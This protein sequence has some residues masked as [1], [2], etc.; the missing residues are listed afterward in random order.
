MQIQITLRKNRTLP[1][2]F[3]VMNTAATPVLG[4]I[5][6]LGKADNAAAN[7]Q[8]NA[9]RNPE[10]SFGDTPTGGYAITALVPHHGETDLH[11]YGP[12]PSV[13]LDPQSG[14][15]LTAKTNGRTGLMIHGGVPSATGGLRPTHGC[16]RLSDANQNALI[17]L[18]TTLSLTTITV[19][20]TEI[21]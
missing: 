9:T 5:L 18:I 6:C 14:Q 16:V 21:P 1:G 10:R 11:T 19:T 7:L 12:H 13:L 2:Q 3:R 15:A 8:G 4:P 20:V 17:A